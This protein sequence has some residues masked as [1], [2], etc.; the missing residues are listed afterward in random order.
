MTDID[1]TKDVM[2]GV[3]GIIRRDDRY[4]IIQRSATVRVPLA[5]CFPGGEIEL[6]ETV[7]AALMRE[8]REELDITVS[9]GR[10]IAVHEKHEGRLILHC[11]TATIDGC[12]PTPNPAEVA[13]CEWLSREE[14]ALLENLLPGTLE[15]IDCASANR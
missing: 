4:L 11:M 14:V 8:M 12:E 1:R 2:H 13:R 3:I 10:L 5:W 15:I 9:P 6:G 7:E